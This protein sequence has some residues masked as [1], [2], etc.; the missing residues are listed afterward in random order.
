L[1]LKECKLL[2]FHVGAPI[3]DS[4]DRNAGPFAQ[5]CKAASRALIGLPT[6][7]TGWR[8]DF[9]KGAFMRASVCR[10]AV[11]MLLVLLPFAPTYAADLLAKT[12]SS[13]SAAVANWTGFY[14]GGN[15][16]SA[17]G[18]DRVTSNL[19]A[20][21]PFLGVDI[22][23][24]SSAA[25]PTLNPTGFTGGVQAGYNWQT[26]S[27]VWGGEADFDYLGL[28]A[29]NSATLP[30]PSTLPGGAAGPP[31]AFFSTST[32]ES[33]SWLFTARQRLGWANENWLIYATGG[34]AVGREKFSQTVALVA[35]F[36]G[37]VA[38]SSTRVGWTVGAGA[39]YALS[40]QW[41]IKAEY[42]HVDLGS[43]ATSATFMPAFAG[44]TL[45][46]TTR[47]TTEIARGGLNYHL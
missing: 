45:A 11:S 6:M 20:P 12:P 23:A 21:A 40:R 43:V 25:S 8:R 18:R 41:S 39:E 35:P 34:L 38:N 36:A 5:M 14:I 3:V 42:L 26:G 32:S 44:L 1:R 28:K 31:T 2:V 46:G 19:N 27:W 16:G 47:L 37:T 22:A 13:A 24:V 10:L 29:S 33:A 15:A 17:W 9:R 4:A 30:F 7:L